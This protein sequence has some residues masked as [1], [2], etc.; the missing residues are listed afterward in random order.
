MSKRMVDLQVEGGKIASIN[1]YEVGGSGGGGSYNVSVTAATE[2][3]TTQGNLSSAQWYR[4]NPLN[5]NTAYEVGD[6]VVVEYS[7]VFNQIT[8]NKDQILVPVGYR[9]NIEDENKT[10]KY[11]DVVLVLTEVGN[12][13]NYQP[14]GDQNFIP[15]I[16]NLLT[17]TVV[18]AGTTGANI[19]LPSS[20]WGGA[21]SYM[22]YTL[23]ATKATE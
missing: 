17:Y 20:G 23:V 10:L 18:K 8:I 15:V 14:K 5:K 4:F 11:G 9:S 22:I 13:M 1:G 6:N 7:K 16:S 21:I 2:N 19:D 3:L 12:I